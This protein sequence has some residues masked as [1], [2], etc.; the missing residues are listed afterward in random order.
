MT[1]P[2]EV[3][4]DHPP[5][6]SL[7]VADLLLR[8]VRD[9]GAATRERPPAPAR[10]QHPRPARAGALPP[11]V[12]RR[13]GPQLRRAQRR[14]AAGAVPVLAHR[15]V[16]TRDATLAGHTPT[17]VVQDALESVPR[18]SPAELTWAR[19]AGADA[20]R[21]RHHPG[22][23]S[24][25]ARDA[26]AG[27]RDRPALPRRRRAGATLCWRSPA[28]VL[29]VVA[30]PDIVVQPPAGP[31]VVRPATRTAGPRLDLTGRRH[32]GLAAARGQRHRRGPSRAGACPRQPA[33]RRSASPTRS[34]R[35]RPGRGRAG[36][37]APGRARRAGRPPPSGSA[38]TTV[39]PGCCRAAVLPAGMRRTGHGRRRR[40][41]GAAGGTDLVGLHEYARATTCVGCTGPPAPA[42]AR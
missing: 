12:R 26:A 38:R 11:G 25:C 32:R 27:A 4:D 36:A 33:R 8:Y 41:L 6:E 19:G 35:S 30:R 5:L 15:T 3:A 24:S 37:A 7:H 39:L 13:P 20:R 42:P 21:R 34:R 10:R 28:E 18:R 9:L 14:P 16:L 17:A 40:S 31:P 1:S 2:D 23:G 29:A 22:V